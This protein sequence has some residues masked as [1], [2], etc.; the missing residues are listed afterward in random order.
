MEST[1]TFSLT[2]HSG[3]AV[4]VFSTEISTVTVQDDDCEFIMRCLC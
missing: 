1:E 2:L 4:D 3:D